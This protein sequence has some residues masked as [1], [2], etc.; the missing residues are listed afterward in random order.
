VTERELLEEA[1]VALAR[2]FYARQD[3]SG[4]AGVFATQDAK[5]VARLADELIGKGW[6]EKIA[7]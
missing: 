6:R 4:L 5:R 3:D 7:E 1:L 2:L